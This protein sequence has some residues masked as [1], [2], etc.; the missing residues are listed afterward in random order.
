MLEQFAYAPPNGFGQFHSLRMINSSG[1]TETL[2]Q[3][4]HNHKN[5]WILV[6]LFCFCIF[7][8]LPDVRT[9]EALGGAVDTKTARIFGAAGRTVINHLIIERL[10]TVDRSDLR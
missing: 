4:F 8:N 10:M 5:L 3:F 2:S 1:W 6:F 9:F 7:R